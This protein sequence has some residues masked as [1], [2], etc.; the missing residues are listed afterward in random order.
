[1][2]E[3]KKRKKPEAQMVSRF[4][5]LAQHCI[6]GVKCGINL[7][8]D[9]LERII[10]VQRRVRTRSTN[11]RASSWNNPRITGSKGYDEYL[12]LCTSQHYLPRHENQEHDLRLEHAI[13]E[14]REQL[15]GC[16]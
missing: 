12:Y 6:D 3:G 11:M 13:D 10:I 5:K 1:M 16:K 15:N 2:I 7:F 8:P 9:L 4:P 14:A